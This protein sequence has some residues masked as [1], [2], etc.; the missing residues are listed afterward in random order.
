MADCSIN[1]RGL[2]AGGKD[3]TYIS[4]DY[5]SKTAPNLLT[6]TAGGAYYRK[7]WGNNDKW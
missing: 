5:L 3:Y 7:T 4:S 1:A 6:N 2:A